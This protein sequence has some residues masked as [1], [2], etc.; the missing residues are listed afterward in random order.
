MRNNYNRTPLDSAA[1]QLEKIA[2][3]PF[4]QPPKES[5]KNIKRLKENISIILKKLDLEDLK[6]ENYTKEALAFI[7]EELIRRKIMKEINNGEKGIE[8]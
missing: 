3:N 1:L 7:K 4:S 2:Q 8:I 5:S 6:K